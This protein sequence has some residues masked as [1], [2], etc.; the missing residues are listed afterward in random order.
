MTKMQMKGKKKKKN[1]YTR[2]YHNYAFMI[3][4][5]WFQPFKHSNIHG[6]DEPATKRAI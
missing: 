3:T 5:D 2:I 4:V 6:T 1:K